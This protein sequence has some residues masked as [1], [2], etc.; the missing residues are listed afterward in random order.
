MTPYGK[1]PPGALALVVVVIATTGCVPSRGRMMTFEEYAEVRHTTP[2]VIDLT[3]GGSGEGHSGGVGRLV[4]FGSRHSYD[5][6]DPQRQWIEDLWQQVGPTIALNEGGDPP[7][8][9]SAEEAVG[10]HG[11]PGLVRHLAAHDDTPVRSLEPSQEAEINH[12]CARFDSNLVTLFLVLR[13]YASYRQTH[14]PEAAESLLQDVLPYLGGFS[15][16]S[17]G[18]KTPETFRAS[19]AHR[20]PDLKDWRDFP[21]SMLDPVRRDQPWKETNEISRATSEFRDAHMVEL[22][23][24]LVERGERVFAVVGASHVVMQEPLLRARLQGQ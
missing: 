11:E 15:A 9:P 4:Y 14:P 6:N 5:P 1:L 22:L 3:L 23:V 16:L 10:R 2:Y 20:F 13:Y 12:L 7:T 24:S 19:M 18:P 17:E 21:A 8:E